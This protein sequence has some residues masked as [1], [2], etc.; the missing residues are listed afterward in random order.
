MYW[1]EPFAPREDVWY[2][3]NLWGAEIALRGGPGGRWQGFCRELPWNRRTGVC[4]G[5]LE[6]KAPDGTAIT[7]L[8]EVPPENTEPQIALTPCLPAKPFLVFPADTLRL[9]PGTETILELE[10]PPVLRLT[11]HSGA[12]AE[13]L[14]TFTPF[15]L[16]ETWYGEDTMTGILCYAL[17]GAA[18]TTAGTAAV[19]AGTAES[20][21]I[22][23]RILLRNR[24]RAILEPGKMPL[25]V[26]ELSVYGQ[27]GAGSLPDA[28]SLSS[29][30][31]SD[32]PV[33]DVYG[34]DDFRISLK[35][36]EADRG[37]KP[38]L[39]VKGSKNG[40]GDLLIH[41]GTQI[42]KNI[43]GLP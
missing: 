36:P 41:H 12:S 39:I 5:P 43:T 34:G 28:G 27:N 23:C 3:W 35:E 7:A 21:G 16:K 8:W 20:A 4:S 30:L 2:R 31:Y 11:L 9:A 6:G 22:R 24:T 29:A 26:E 10:I 17:P 42:I 32:M 40:M 14:F 33:I 15:T 37:A 13:L 19:A 38:A 1:W 18:G 25:R